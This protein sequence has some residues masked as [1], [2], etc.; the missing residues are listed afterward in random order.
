[1][2]EEEYSTAGNRRQLTG[3]VF[4]KD[5]RVELVYY[6]RLFGLHL[7]GQV[8]KLNRV[9]GDGS[10]NTWQPGKPLSEP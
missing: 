10:V 1:M 9:L 6:L 5:V 8:A 4:P 2:T 7:R 3:T